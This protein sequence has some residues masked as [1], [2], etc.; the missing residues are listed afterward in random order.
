MEC[1]FQSG[2]CLDSVLRVN[3]RITLRLEGDSK[4]FSVRRIVINNK[5]LHARKVFGSKLKAGFFYGSCGYSNQSSSTSKLA[6]QLS[7]SRHFPSSWVMTGSWAGPAT[8][9]IRLPPA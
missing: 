6:L 5:D 4:Q 3:H 8:S 2:E 9:P 1:S 7:G